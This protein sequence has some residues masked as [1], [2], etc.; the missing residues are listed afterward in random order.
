M[1]FY[2]HFDW[3]IEGKASHNLFKWIRVFK[4]ELNKRS[5]YDFSY[6]DW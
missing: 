6:R 5:D 2:M 4:H 3:Q 1:L